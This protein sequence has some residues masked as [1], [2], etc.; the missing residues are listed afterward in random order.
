MDY[1]KINNETEEKFSSSDFKVGDIFSEM[2]SYWKVI[3][4]VEGET[5]TLISGTAQNL[6]I[7]VM[8]KSDFTYRCSY[9]NIPGYWIQFM[10][11]DI[12]RCADYLEAYFKQSGMNLQDIREMKLDLVL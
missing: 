8:S 11:N 6:K 1:S 2:L 3:I 12:S 7:E 5:L 4:K 10:K 9:K